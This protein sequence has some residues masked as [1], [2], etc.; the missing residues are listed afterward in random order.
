M[1][2]SEKTQM[3]MAWRR[4][5]GLLAKGD[6]VKEGTRAAVDMVLTDRDHSDEYKRRAVGELRQ[7]EG[8][9]YAALSAEVYK[10]MSD[11]DTMEQRIQ[12]RFRY[13]SPKLLAALQF[14]DRMGAG[15][16]Y[17]IRDQLAEDFRGDAGALRCIREKYRSNDFSTMKL[18]AMIAPFDSLTNPAEEAASELAAY[19]QTT[20]GQ[21]EW[22]SAGVRAVMEKQMECYGV[23]F[24]NAPILAELEEIRD[25]TSDQLKAAKISA[26]IK[27]HGG[28]VYEEFNNVITETTEMHE[29]FLMGVRA[30]EA[31]G[32]V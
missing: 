5:A 29:H 31:D 27:A 12:S 16:P 18:D 28:E 23:T 9:E 30:G 1:K 19:G 7:R 13:D 4:V 17:E 3:T 22:R 8:E 10:I 20:Y 15:M 32:D 25:N 26:W 2:R 14:I 24:D 11:I 6:K 21:R